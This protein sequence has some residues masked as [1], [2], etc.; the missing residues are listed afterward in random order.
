M[1]SK[2]IG[3]EL[4]GPLGATREYKAEKIAHLSLRFVRGE[5]SLAQKKEQIEAVAALP[6]CATAAGE[7]A[8]QEPPDEVEQIVASAATASAAHDLLMP[9]RTSAA[10]E[11]KA[12][13]ETAAASLLAEEAAEA[14]A[15]RRKHAKKA[16]RKEAKQAKH[17][18]ETS[19]D[20]TMDVAAGD[21][22]DRE[23][24]RVQERATAVEATVGCGGVATEA[25]GLRSDE[26][27]REKKPKRR[28]LSGKV[29]G[30]Q[31]AGNDSE[32]EFS[33]T[34]VL[35]RTNMETPD[36]TRPT[37]AS[38]A[39]AASVDCEIMPM[40]P[41]QRQRLKAKR[42]PP[43]KGLLPEEEAERKTAAAET[44]A[45][46]AET[47]AAAAETEAAAAETA[48]AAAHV[49]LRSERIRLNVPKSEGFSW[50]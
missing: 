29:V 35:A 9:K 32:S 23:E 20:E 39:A 44:V 17:E 28:V 25:A 43:P 42:R 8:Q 49:P 41:M 3:L 2:P 38:T 19:C 45:A 18:T 47:A 34:S 22:H 11:A 5:I 15:Q 10:S 14:E 6:S 37:H 46:A 27:P 26:R 21:Q 13:A 1:L 12:A 7:S 33:M 16:K 48:A 40:S 50:S 30:K 4:G 36:S 31:P 24:E